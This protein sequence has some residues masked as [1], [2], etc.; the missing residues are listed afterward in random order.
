ML[1]NDFACRL[2]GYSRAQ[3]LDMSGE[4]LIADEAREST[5]QAY[6]QALREPAD[7]FDGLPLRRSNGATFLAEI[8]SRQALLAGRDCLVGVFVD[9]SVRLHQ[10]Q[11]RQRALELL[12]L[13]EHSAHAG[14]WS[15]DLVK[16]THHW[17][18]ALL[19]LFREGGIGL[20]CLMVLAS[21]DDPARL[22]DT[23]ASSGY[24]SQA[25]HTMSS[26]AASGTKSLMS[27]ATIGV[28]PMPPPT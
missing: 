16:D 19:Q 9:I 11:E 21:I 4:D 28:R 6:E 24:T 15:W 7:H 8:H 20:D 17:S 14:A 12:S 18:P 2:F 22:A 27:G 10:E 13:A 26:S 23:Y 3:M 25:P 1:V 5:L